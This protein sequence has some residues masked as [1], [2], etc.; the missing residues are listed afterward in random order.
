MEMLSMYT[1]FLGANR[2]IINGIAFH[3]TS[4]LAP[5]LGY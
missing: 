1:K 4:L 2:G 5:K 3:L